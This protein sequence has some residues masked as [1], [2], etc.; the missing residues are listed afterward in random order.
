MNKFFF[1]FSVIIFVIGSNT[2]SQTTDPIRIAVVG[3]THGHVN[4]FFR[5][6]EFG[7]M[8]KV[9]GVSEPQ[10]DL[11]E[12]MANRY[13]LDQKIVLD[14]LET[15]LDKTEPEAVAV[16][17][18]T[19]KHK[20]VVLACAKR[21]IHVMMEKPLAV[22]MQ[23][24][25]AMQ[26]AAREGKIH[27][28]VNYET[29]WYPSN[30]AIYDLVQKNKLGPLRKIVVR[31]GHPGPVEIGCSKYFLEWLTDPIK[32]GGGALFDFGC[33]G[34]NLVTWLMNNQKPISVTAIAQTIKPDVYPYVDDEATIL[35][36]YPQAQ[37]IIQASWNWPFN[38][39]DM[40]VYGKTGYAKALNETDM[41]VRFEDDQEKEIK[42]KDLKNPYQSSLSYFAAIIRGEIQPDGL[43]SL[44]NN[45]IVTEIL[46]AARASATQ[47]KTIHLAK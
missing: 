35:L 41:R 6:P 9:V 5:Q 26:Q 46:E 32:N 33:Y 19:Y 36:L 22:N 18:S 21:G 14:D 31:A 43:S 20:D 25:R 37:A 1:A 34:A 3:L 23:H 7:S 47:A 40:D 45:L 28:I 17:T 42:P 8:M 12:S 30:H 15:M 2:F 24:A 16:Y 10:E 29:T 13:Q 27:V 39:K 4:G 11:R 38:R 44:E